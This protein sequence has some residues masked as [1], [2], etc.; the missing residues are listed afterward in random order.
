MSM[1]EEEALHADHAP[2]DRE[3]PL[4]S[5]RTMEF[6]TSL[7]LLALAAIVIWESM[8]IGY[9]WIDGQGPA[10]GFFPFIVASLMGLASIANIVRVA[11]H[12]A[13]SKDPVFVTAAGFG[14]VLSVLIPVILYVASISYL[15]IYVASAIFIALFMI[16]IGREPL[17][18][19][20]AI[21][22]TVSL[23]L[24]LTFEQWFRVPLPKGPLEA[25]LGY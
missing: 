24:F 2:E 14:R 9:G 7:S 15:G 21:S 6:A 3:H 10:S 18:K 12:G 22:I 1:T 13:E 20:L 16:V 19:A 11:L 8:R 4:V 17:W 5:A 23:L 25:W